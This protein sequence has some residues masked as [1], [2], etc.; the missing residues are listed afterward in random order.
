MTAAQV[1][2]PSRVDAFVFKTAILGRLGIKQLDIEIQKFRTIRKRPLQGFNKALLASHRRPQNIQIR[3]WI[4]LK[5]VLIYA[6]VQMDCQLRNAEKLIS[7][8]QFCL[9]LAFQ[10]VRQ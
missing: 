4:H 7:A 6:S 8:N 5:T 10:F 9:Y 1:V 3:L 2:E